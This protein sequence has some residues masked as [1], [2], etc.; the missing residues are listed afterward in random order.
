MIA[1]IVP[2][3]LFSDENIQ[4]LLYASKATYIN[5]KPIKNEDPN[6]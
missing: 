1:C 4:T 6:K 3:D 5:N 2:C